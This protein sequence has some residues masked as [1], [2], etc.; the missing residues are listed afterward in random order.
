MKY[1]Y[2]SRGK[3]FEVT[4]ERQGNRY[5]ALIDDLVYECEVL[6]DQPGAIT[7]RVDGQ[8]VTVYWAVDGTRKWASQDGCTYLLERPA[9]RSRSLQAERVA[10]N[11][12]RAPMP[13]Q[14]R[15]V[16]VEPGAE[17]QE[18]QTLLILEAMKMEIRLQA[19]RSGRVTRLWVETGQQVNRDQA[20]VELDDSPPA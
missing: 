14:V 18:G 19:P 6:D 13:A 2:A 5:R 4:L 17:V 9:A 1:R 8:P 16:E 12:L 11:I 7:L 10:E 20:L 15:T 3:L